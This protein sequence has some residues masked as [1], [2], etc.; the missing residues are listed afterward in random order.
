MRIDYLSSDILQFRGDSLAALATAFVDGRRVLLVDA[1]ASVEDALEMRRYLEGDLGLSV[2]S[3]VLTRADGAH[4]DGI[5]LFPGATLIAQR[6]NP[7]APAPAVVV[8]RQLSLAWGRHRLDLFASGAAAASVL[9]IDVPTADLLFAGAGL[10][11]GV[12]RIGAALPDQ[13]DTAIAHLQQRERG[14]I[15]PAH[16][17]VQDGGALGAARHYLARLGALVG[18]ARA[19]QPACRADAAI[20]AIRVEDCL[21]A[22]IHATALDRHWH[23]ENLRQVVQRQLFPAAAAGRRSSPGRLARFMECNCTMATLVAMLGRLGR[24]GV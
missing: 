13:V 17:G 12:A 1:L 20:E 19:G 15:V 8:D 14:R 10:S 21:A 24:S 9:A 5:A 22:G 2:A 18:A 7:L 16:G 6:G 3:I 4:P 11:G 23:A